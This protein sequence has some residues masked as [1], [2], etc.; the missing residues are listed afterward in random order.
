MRDANF[1]SSRRPFFHYLVFVHDQAAGTSSSGLCC[2][3]NRDY[4]A[5]LGSWRL[6]CIGPGPNGVRN[7]TP[8]GDDVISGQGIIGGPNR[9]CDSTAAGDDTQDQ[10]VGGGAADYE[11]GTVRDQSGTILHE[12]GHAL[13]LGH[14]GVEGTNYKPNYLSVMNYAFDPGGVPDRTNS[15][16]R[17][18]YSR[19]ALPT[20]SR[21]RSRRT[22]ASATATRSR[23]GR[24]Q[25]AS[26][27]VLRATRR[28]TGTTRA[29]SRAGPSTSTSTTTGRASAPVRTVRS[30]PHQ[31]A[32][33]SSPERTSATDR[34][35]P[36]TPSGPATTSRTSTIRSVA[37][38]SGA[39]ARGTRR[40]RVTT[41]P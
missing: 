10:T 20:W 6:G 14:G 11:V 30:R 37:S 38:A 1:N 31:A 32:M 16:Y 5:S 13:G 18:D 26:S 39:T 40:R 28:S 3:D 9:T 2:S 34:T 29:G 22:R 17:L 36:A 24:I 21:R 12:L 15:N 19:S 33:T 23:C 25:R 35:M 8:T 27:A 41:S 4:I 7:T